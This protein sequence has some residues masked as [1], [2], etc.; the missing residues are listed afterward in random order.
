M[1]YEVGLPRKT[2][3]SKK[4]E[5]DFINKYNGMKAIYRTVYNFE[6]MN[7]YKPDYNSA[8][9]NKLFFDFDDND[10]WNEANRLHQFLIKENIKHYIIMSGKGYHIFILTKDY[11]PQNLKSCIYNSQHY[12][13]DKLNLKCDS[14]VV[15]DNARLHRIPNTYNVKAKRFC[16]PITKEQFK[17]GDIIIKQ[18]AQYQNFIKNISI[19][20][21]LFDVSR[22]DYKSDKFSDKIIV[23]NSNFENNLNADYA[24]KS[25]NFIKQLLLKRDAGWNDR[26]LLILFFRDSGYTREEVFQILKDNLT[27]RKFKH[28]VYE[29]RQLQYLFERYDLCFPEKYCKI[30]K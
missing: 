18:A 30:Y 22:Y 20:T 16:I 25:P 5:A 27:E 21:E 15:G 6:L 12:F 11:K 4:E 9:V 8:I 1:I 7:D 13:I 2:I 14:Q 29:E 19:G 26:Y 24:T 3:N 28:C 23:D 17:S 10:C